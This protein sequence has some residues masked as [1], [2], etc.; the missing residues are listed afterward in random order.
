MGDNME[1]GEVKS[2]TRPGKKI[3]K[4]YCNCPGGKEKIVHAG[5]KGYGNNYSDK[6][7]KAFNA[8]HKCSDA[9]PCTPKHLACTELWKKGGRK[10]EPPKT[11]RRRQIKSEYGIASAVL[12]P[13]P[14]YMAKAQSSSPK[15]TNMTLYNKIKA[16]VYKKI[17][18]H[19]AYR[20]SIVVKNYKAAGGGYSGSK[21]KGGLTRWHK[22]KWRNQ[23]GKEGYQKKGDIYRPTK[24]VSKKTPITM[25]ELTESEK[26][27]ARNIKAK[28]KRV[29]RFRKK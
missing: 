18:K 16:Q 24:R 19:S 14:M 25:S 12:E 20:S 11:P 17:P 21:E 10:T 5:A 29:T 26:K 22:E 23:R 1:C 28:G 7:R 9:K 8:R 3:M 4:K 15:P 27:R 6:A 13:D 2:S